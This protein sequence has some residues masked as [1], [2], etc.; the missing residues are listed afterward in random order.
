[1][2]YS[3]SKNMSRQYKTV[4]QHDLQLVYIFALKPGTLRKCYGLVQNSRTRTT[5]SKD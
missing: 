2:K 5:R 4:I 3:F 1:L